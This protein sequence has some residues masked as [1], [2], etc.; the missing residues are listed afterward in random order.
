MRISPKNRI[1]AAVKVTN[2]GEILWNIYTTAYAV[3]DSDGVGVKIQS[4]GKTDSKNLFFFHSDA[5]GLNFNSNCTRVD[6]IKDVVE[7]VFYSSNGDFKFD[8]N[9]NRF[10][11][12]TIL[13]D[14]PDWTRTE[15]V[16][17]ILE[18]FGKNINFWHHNMFLIF[19]YIFMLALVWYE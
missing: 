10:K 12:N 15:S 17:E 5:F 2:N 4:N 13:D 9:T 14:F 3:S 7:G 1:Q 11:N 6:R 8:F 18:L 16:D 19:L